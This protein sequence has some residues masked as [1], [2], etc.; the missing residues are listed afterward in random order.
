MKCEKPLSDLYQEYVMCKIRKKELEGKI[1]QYLLDNQERFH[2]FKGNS[3]RWNEYLSWLYSRLS[4][5]IDL[6]RDMGSSF[7]AYI[8]SLVHRAAKEYRCR[9]TDHYVTEY[10][11]WQARA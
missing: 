6:Y 2:I 3:D 9:E 4:R 1:F 8:T 10:T 11:C 7:D 5:A